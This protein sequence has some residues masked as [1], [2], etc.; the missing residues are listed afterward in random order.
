[1]TH[2]VIVTGWRDATEQQHHDHIRAALLPILETHGT[3]VI[4]RHGQCPYGGVDLIADHIAHRWGWTVDRMPP[5][6]VN[7]RI[8]GQQRNE[9]MCAKGADEV[10]AFPGPG[11]RGTWGCLKAATNRGIPSRIHPITATPRETT[12]CPS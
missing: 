5:E 1:M 2:A 7:G 11:S 9:A 10:I 4:L 8:K 12:P 3:D 6:V